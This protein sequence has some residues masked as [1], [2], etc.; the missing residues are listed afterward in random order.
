VVNVVN[1]HVFNF[2]FA[3]RTNARFSE[4]W[5]VREIVSQRNNFFLQKGTLTTLEDIL[6]DRN[7]KL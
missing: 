4:N 6:N 1:A 2:T 3:S 7:D 5:F